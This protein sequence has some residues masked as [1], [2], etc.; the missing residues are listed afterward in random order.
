[1]T[2]ENVDRV[3]AVWAR[4]Y[5]AGKSLPE[6]FSE[7][8]RLSV[9]RSGR[10]FRVRLAIFIALI[11]A[12]V[13]LAVGMA[14]RTK[15]LSDRKESLVAAKGDAE[16]ECVTGWALLGM[17]RECFRRGKSGKKKEEE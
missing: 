8:L 9:R 3:L 4:D 7:R 1:M 13:T 15:P 10:T 16:E 5:V 14:G 12:T 17:F 11:A 6:E 2:E